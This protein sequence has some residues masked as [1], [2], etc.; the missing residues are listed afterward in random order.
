VFARQKSI[1]TVG[2]MGN[3]IR[4]DAAEEPY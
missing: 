2:E 4:M 1:D 3:G